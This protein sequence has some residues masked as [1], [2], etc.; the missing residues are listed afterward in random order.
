M[1][2][3]DP[4]HK[5]LSDIH[6]SID[7]SKKKSKYKRI[8]GMF[9]PAYL[10]SVGYMDPGNWATDLAG[11]SQFGYAL[12][13][14]LLMSNI[15]AL[16]L[17][18]L[19]A[20][21]GVVRGKD[22][23]QCN[24]ETYPKKV[25]FALYILAEIAIAACDLAEVLGMAIGLH[26]LFGIDIIWG[27]LISFA[28]T[29]LLL[30]LQ[31]LGMRK[32]E[33][34]IIG[35]ISLIGMC[36]M[37]EMFL[38]KP[39]FAEVATGLIPS[40]PNSAALY[41]AIGI[42]GATVM[43]HNLYLHSALVQTRKID[44][45]AKSI[46]RSL[47]YNFWDSAIALNMAFFVNAAILILAASVFHKNGLHEVA[48]LD[49][50]YH[51]LK[52]ILGTELAPKLFAVALILAGQSSTVTG[53][54]AGQIV[55]EGYLRLRISPALRRIITRLLAI[56]PAVLV[57]LI[58]GEDHVGQLLIFSQV[59]LSMQLAFAVIP[60]IHFVSDKN[61]MGIFVINNL[62]KVFAWLIAAVIAILNF[63]LV[64]DELYKWI[65]NATNPLVPMLVIL[66]ALGLILL[67][68]IT[69]FYPIFW[70]TKTVETDVHQSFEPIAMETKKSFNTILIALDFS[71]SDQ[72][73]IQYAL[74]LA[75]SKSKFVLIH[76]V[77]SASVKYDG[78]SSDDLES[79]QDLERLKRFAD[80]LISNGHQ[81]Q[82]ELGYNNRIK[83]IVRFCEK[84]QADLLIV[85]SHGHRG[86]KDFIFGE[87]VNK[88]RHA[89]NIPVFIA[90]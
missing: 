52:N 84:Y 19:C 16:L 22:L 60:L 48:E 25:N 24:R 36:F 18:N 41:I 75:D 38:A 81:T 85:G 72:K 87:T 47:K 77:E 79:R 26:L 31:K 34:F 54:L 39:D 33:L 43:P 68:L 89:V 2:Q 51:L 32:M 11:G 53:T 65:Q 29:F 62:T 9:G 28:D 86:F 40:I 20:R 5:S 37:V 56:I 69:F 15:M 73:V 45:D 4:Q 3:D 58:S 82:F 13:W 55:M 50:A 7:I 63:K 74:Q 59:I 6:E 90:K 66:L 27:V 83:N 76:I 64:Y 8:L 71:I 61:K 42:I 10:I 80:F 57:I 67:L 49:D 46:K 35:L 14:V 78:N 30:Y 21:L 44:R 1:Y 17:Q 88:L 70:K 12:L 23:A